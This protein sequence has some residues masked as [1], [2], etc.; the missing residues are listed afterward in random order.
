MPLDVVNTDEPLVRFK[1]TKLHKT[2]QTIYTLC[3]LHALGKC[4]V[5]HASLEKHS[6]QLSF[7]ENE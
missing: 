6:D 5:R 2:G 1:F 7:R 4:E 3:W